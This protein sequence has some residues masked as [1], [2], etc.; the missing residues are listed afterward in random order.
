MRLGD[1]YWNQGAQKTRESFR[2]LLDII[3]DPAFS[4]STVSEM[5]WSAV[6]KELGQ[7]QFDGDV[8]EWLGHD[9]GWK[10]SS[11][12]IL[13][14]FHS[15]CSKPGL[16]S[17]T[18]DGFYHRS[19]VSIIKEKLENPAHA[20]FFHFEPY[21]LQW[22][23]PHRQHDIKV[24]SELF[25]STVFVEA[26]KVL[27]ALPGEPSCDL[28][29]VVVVLMFWSNTTKLTAFGDTKLWPLYMFFGNESKY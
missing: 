18:V 14:P 25:S 20:T 23:P 3:G 21:E 19:L 17:Y 12:T 13:V 22:R 5:V 27:Q 24:Y 15:W 11:A 10:C 29:R 4:P 26:N 8:P 16:T 9:E 1:W 2:Q 7:N 6:D 28:P